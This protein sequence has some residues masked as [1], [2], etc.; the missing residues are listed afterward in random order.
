MHHTIVTAWLLVL[1]AGDHPA[2]SVEQ[3]DDG[4]T[5]QL[6]EHGGHGRPAEHRQHRADH[7]PPVLLPCIRIRG[8]P[9]PQPLVFGR[10]L[11]HRRSEDHRGHTRV[12][13][14]HQVG[15]IDVALHGLLECLPTGWIVADVPAAAM[16]AGGQQVMPL[17]VQHHQRLPR[18]G[19]LHALGQLAFEHLGTLVPLLCRQRHE[20]LQE[21]V[22]HDHPQV[23]PGQ[24]HGMLHVVQQALGDHVLR[25]DGL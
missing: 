17:L 15:V 1:G 13:R 25:G 4:R 24:A 7:R 21:L 2:L 19:Q 18:T 3:V 10:S 22:L 5:T 11:T 6:I 16:A 20:S 23:A 14:P 8:V 12:V 9:L